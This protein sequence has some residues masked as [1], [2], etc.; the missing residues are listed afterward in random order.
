MTKK[1][2]EGPFEILLREFMA[3]RMS[4]Q[5]GNAR[6][7]RKEKDAFDAG[8]NCGQ[9]CVIANG[10]AN[11]WADVEWKTYQKSKKERG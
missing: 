10:E 8:F 4:S 2:D 7:R 5:T 3:G 11:R 9:E 6:I 1:N